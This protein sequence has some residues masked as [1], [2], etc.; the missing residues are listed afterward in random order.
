MHGAACAV[1]EA[2]RELARFHGL[3]QRVVGPGH[4]VC[5]RVHKHLRTRL[6]TNWQ[7]LLPAKVDQVA[8][9]PFIE[10]PLQT[11]TFKLHRHPSPEQGR[12]SRHGQSLLVGAHFGSDAPRVVALPKPAL[13]LDL[14]TLAAGLK[15]PAVAPKLLHTHQVFGDAPAAAAKVRLFFVGVEGRV[16]LKVETHARFIFVQRNPMPTQPFDDLNLQWAD[17]RAQWVRPQPARQ[18]QVVL[19]GAYRDAGKAVHHVAVGVIADSEI[20]D[21]IAVRNWMTGV[22]QT[23]HPGWVAAVHMVEGRRGLVANQVI[24][25]CEHKFSVGPGKA[26]QVLLTI[27]T[28]ACAVYQPSRQWVMPRAKVPVQRV[29]PSSFIRCMRFA[30]EEAGASLPRAITAN[31]GRGVSAI[32][33]RSSACT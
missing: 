1:G 32:S 8:G 25:G 14:K 4:V 27:N 5:D 26:G 11:I 13:G 16:V 10:V 22:P 18:A 28:L 30:Q 15:P 2:E 17:A 19:R 31:R 20:E 21:H 29:L 33:R 9:R 7:G 12:V 23:L 6:G 3:P 24:L